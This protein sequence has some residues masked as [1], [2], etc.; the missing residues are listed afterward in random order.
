MLDPPWSGGC[1]YQC[2]TCHLGFRHPIRPNQD[3]E[4]LYA[5]ASEKVWLTRQLRA[6]QLR[7]VNFVQTHL[8]AAQVLDVGCYDG[9][10]LQALGPAY[11]KFG[12]EPSERAAAVARERG[13]QM[14]AARISELGSLRRS[15]DVVCAVDVVEHVAQPADLVRTL[16]HVLSPG[17]WLLVSTGLLDTSA[18]RQVGGQYWYCGFPEHIS[19]VSQA[20]AKAT[21]T[22]LGIELRQL[23]R[24][25]YE[26]L[27]P[28][29]KAEAHRRFV[30][31]AARSA[32]SR[33]MA[34]WLNPQAT[35]QPRSSLGQP[36][37]FEDHVLMA[38]YKPAGA[39]G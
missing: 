34:G 15:F 21:A 3:Y 16:V 22:R 32:W 12:V 6:D 31:R 7:V 14:L 19:F 23:D 18:W 9:S 11:G 29:L 5:S 20:W 37:V 10:L 4:Q 8:P 25:V 28:D 26:T 38:F 33:R 30:R 17:G 2:Q 27:P 1:L 39:G 36:G 35:W 13:V 24:F